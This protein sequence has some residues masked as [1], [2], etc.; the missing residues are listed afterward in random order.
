MLFNLLPNLEYARLG[1][2]Q[3]RVHEGGRTEQDRVERVMSKGVV[4]YFGKWC[5][6][7]PPDIDG[8]KPTY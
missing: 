2:D 8:V 7:I 3:V 4:R 5:M 1:R 6:T